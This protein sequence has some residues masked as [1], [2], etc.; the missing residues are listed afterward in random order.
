LPTDG[1]LVRF[2]EARVHRERF[3]DRQLLVRRRCPQIGCREPGG[4]FRQ[5][6]LRRP[7]L[8][9]VAK[10]T[11]G[12][13]L[14][15]EV[16]RQTVNGTAAAIGHGDLEFAAIDLLLAEIL[17]G[18]NLALREPRGAQCHAF[19]AAF[20]SEAVSIEVIAVEDRELQIDVLLVGPH[21]VRK[22]LLRRKRLVVLCARKRCRQ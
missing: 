2:V 13:A 7:I 17:V 19:R 3:V 4:R 21:G 16:Q 8:R 6:D 12:A 9:K 10:A 18:V 14:Q 1:E 11:I 20:E 5:S 15:L 22:Y